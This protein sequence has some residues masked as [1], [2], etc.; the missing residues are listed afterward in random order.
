MNPIPP[1]LPADTPK[2]SGMPTWA[3]VLIIVGGVGLVVMVLVAVVG[4]LAAIAIPNFVRARET[5]QRN[6]CISNLRQI[7]AAKQQWATE[8]K[9][10]NGDPVDENQI[11]QY[12]KSSARPVC[13]KGGTYIYSPVGSE[14]SCSVHGTLSEAEA[15]RTSRTRY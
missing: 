15:Q 3:L 4:L 2:K 10:E 1:L 6:V 9:K 12:L 5:A 13:L 8:N 11:N 14:P 7:D